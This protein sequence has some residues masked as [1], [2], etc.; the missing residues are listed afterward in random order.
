MTVNLVKIRFNLDSSDGHGHCS[1]TL[2]A[3]PIPETAC[4]QILNSPFFARGINHRDTVNATA[5]ESNVFDFEGIEKRGGHSTFM[6]LVVPTEKRFDVYWGILERMGCS[7]ESATLEMSMGERRLFSVDVPPAA[8]LDDVCETLER[9]RN[10][11]IWI[12]QVGSKF[13]SS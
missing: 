6:V 9:G 12:F 11:G 13:K 5:S 4:F 3:A 2:W 10:D 8:D 1:E 7:Y